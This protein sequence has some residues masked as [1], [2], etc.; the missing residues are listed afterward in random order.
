M[1]T[2][3]LTEQTGGCHMGGGWSGFGEIGKGRKN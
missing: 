1:E 3:S 2:D